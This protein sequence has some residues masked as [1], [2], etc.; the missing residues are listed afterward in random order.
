MAIIL[1]PLFS[2]SEVEKIDK[3]YD[4]HP[5]DVNEVPVE[6]R[7]FQVIGVVT[8]PL[9]VKPDRNQRNYS[10]SYVQKV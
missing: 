7:D 3:W 8:S 2:V 6:R 5:H 4:E 10:S 1:L 9:K